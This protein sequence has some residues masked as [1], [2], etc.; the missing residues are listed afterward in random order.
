MASP[1]Q[2]QEPFPQEFSRSKEGQA[3]SSRSKGKADFCSHSRFLQ[4][5]TYGE[6]RDEPFPLSCAPA[7]S[8]EDS[9]DG[10]SLL[11]SVTALTWG[12]C[13]S[14]IA[15]GPFRRAHKGALSWELEPSERSAGFQGTPQALRKGPPNP[16]AGFK[17]F[18]KGDKRTPL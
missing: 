6:G 4:P 17:G 15:P 1:D 12:W 14:P 18:L 11:G 3:Q 16:A 7:A 9:Q 5:P 2:C 10:A 13:C 8:Q